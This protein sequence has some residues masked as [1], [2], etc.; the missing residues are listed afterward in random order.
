[1]YGRQVSNGLGFGLG[2]L[3]GLFGYFLFPHLCCYCLSHSPIVTK[4]F[5]WAYVLFHAICLCIPPCQLL[6]PLQ[7]SQP[8]LT[9]GVEPPGLVWVAQP[10]ADALLADLRWKLNCLPSGNKQCKSP[11]PSCEFWYDDNDL[12][13]MPHKQG[14]FC[15]SIKKYEMAAWKCNLGEFFSLLS[16]DLYTTKQRQF[17]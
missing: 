11:E 15:L 7:T 4:Q 13:N 2:F 1:M 5:R 17:F 3:F 6:L 14:R 16:I 8:S 9:K 10:A 12:T